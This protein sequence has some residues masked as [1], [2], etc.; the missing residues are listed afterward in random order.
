M[1]FLNSCEDK[2]L[3][4]VIQKG[5][6]DYVIATREHPSEKELYAAKELQKYLELISSVKCL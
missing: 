4:T 5:K 2:S 6:S 1:V 3:I